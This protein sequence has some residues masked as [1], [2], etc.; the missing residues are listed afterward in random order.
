MGHYRD[1]SNVLIEL[2]SMLQ[3][4]KSNQNDLLN[5]LIR[6]L[7]TKFNEYEEF[8]QKYLKTTRAFSQRQGINI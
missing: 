8:F 5:T 1:A 4:E 6:S 3:L 2:F 7:M